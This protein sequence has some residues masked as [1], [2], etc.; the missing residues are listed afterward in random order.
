MSS[1][2]DINAGDESL[3]VQAQTVNFLGLGYADTKAMLLDLLKENFPRL[4][5]EAAAVA[6]ARAEEII[7]KFMRKLAEESPRSF[8]NLK[9]PGVQMAVLQVQREYARSGDAD[10]GDL[11][12]DMLV[13]RAGQTG[14][15]LR[16]LVLDG[17][18]NAVPSITRSGIDCLTVIWF[19]KNTQTPAGNVPQFYEILRQQVIPFTSDLVASNG[20]LRH[21][22]Y[23]GCVSIGISEIPLMRTVLMNYQGIFN[24]GFERTEAG[25]EELIN[26]GMLMPCLRDPRK[27]QI[28][29]LNDAALTT[30]IGDRNLGDKEADI[31]RLFNTGSMGIAEIEADIRHNIPAMGT[32]IDLWASSS[33]K[34]ANLTSVGIA[35]AHANWRRATGR[36]EDVDIWLA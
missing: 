2:Q 12:V 26:T 31:R 24:K 14:R 9:D 10:I 25:V 11:L 21:L 35:I 1:K 4:L 30:L 5:E 32:V 18:L 34:N 15:T 7:D 29:A 3:N 33:M 8:A 20:E 16:Q 23:A 28:N 6:T 27:L 13:D 17:A 19:F 36:T 22:E